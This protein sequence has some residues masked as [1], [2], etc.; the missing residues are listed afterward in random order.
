MH[1]LL[2][3]LI[4]W[5]GAIII[6]VAF[7]LTSFEITNSNSFLYQSMNVTG[8]LA[9]VYYSST[10]KDYPTT[11]LNVFWALIATLAIVKLF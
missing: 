8:A 1:R 5:Y 6:L 7:A 3:N 4:G 10:K 11:V 9:L 2:H